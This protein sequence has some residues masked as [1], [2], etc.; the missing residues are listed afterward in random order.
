MVCGRGAWAWAWA[1]EWCAVCRV[2]VRCVAGAVRNLLTDRPNP[3][4]ALGL[5]SW[6]LGHWDEVNYADQPKANREPVKREAVRC[7]ADSCEA[8]TREGCDGE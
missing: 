7:G 3:E 5:V 2:V 6:L 4:Q 8:W 1:W